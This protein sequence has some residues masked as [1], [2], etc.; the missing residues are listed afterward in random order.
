MK[1]PSRSVGFRSLVASVLSLL[2]IGSLWDLSGKAH[3]AAS[4]VDRAQTSSGA[5]TCEVI[6]FGAAILVAYNWR[7]RG[8]LNRKG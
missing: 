1:N 7:R 2:A 3:A 6:A 4:V 5:S 8:H